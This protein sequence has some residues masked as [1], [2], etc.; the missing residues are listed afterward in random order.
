[1]ARSSRPPLTELERRA[2][3]R[4]A[5]LLAQAGDQPARRAGYEELGDEPR[6]ARR[7]GRDGRSR[8]HGGGAGARGAAAGRAP[9]RRRRYPPV[10][11]AA[12]G[13]RAPR[14]RRGRRP[15]RRRRA[16]KKPPRRRLRV[17][18]IDGRLMRR[19]GAISLRVAGGPW[20]PRR[21]ASRLPRPRSHV[22]VPLRDPAVSRRHAA[23]PARAATASRSRTPARAVASRVGGAR[24]DAPLPLRGAAS[25][26]LGAAR[27]CASPP[28]TGRSRSRGRGGLDRRPARARG[29][30]SGVPRAAVSRDRR[31]ALAL[32]PAARAWSGDPTSPCASTATSSGPAA[33][34]STATSSRSRARTAHSAGD[35]LTAPRPPKADR[36]LDEAERAE[37]AGDLAAAAVALRGH[38]DAAPRRRRA[39]CASLRVLTALGER[40]RRARALL[41]PLEAA[42]DR[43]PVRRA[44][45]SAASPSWTRRTAPSWRPRAL[46]ADPGR[47]HR[48]PAGAR[49]PGAAARRDPGRGAVDDR[50]RRRR[51]SSPAGVE[52][53]ALPPAARARA[54]R[55]RDR[56]PGARRGLDLE[57]AL[58]VLHPQ[59]AGAGRRRRAPPV[60]RRGARS[61]PACATRAS[62]PSTT[63]TRPPALAGDGV[64]R[65]AARCAT[66][67]RAQPG[68]PAA[69]TSCSATA[70][71]PARRAG[72][73]PRRAASS[74]AISS[75]R[76]C[77]C[78][79]P[80]RSC[81]PTS[82]SAE[83]AGDA[84]RR[85][86][87][88]PGHAALPRPRAVRGRARLA[89]HRSLRRGRDP[90]GSDVR[91]PAAQ[92]RRPDA[93]RAAAPSPRSPPTSAAAHR[94]PRSG[95][96]A[97]SFGVLVLRSLGT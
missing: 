65:R 82:A 5:A 96:A 44:R 40:A 39:G 73:R 1:M 28:V 57:V 76:T 97:P 74:T 20:V 66:R 92:P 71:E 41:A 36:L 54:R 4:A 46:G 62:S 68:G 88:P 7:L 87:V 22:E 86:R 89:R 90:L 70:R 9:R 94:R 79:R 93:R 21:A 33:I 16:W 77:S 27:P 67:L 23:A 35:R 78:A 32:T 95:A 31:P 51:W 24:V 8:S 19:R 83:L 12:G 14:R 42:G 11:V 59:L 64:R 17:A 10:R 84:A 25:S 34:C 81:W 13:R 18:R 61:P 75:R 52:T 2:L 85:Q 91:P 6:A 69:P 56:L 37:Q 55:D 26:A 38:L 53:L 63:S 48:R 29:R 30:R 45:R 47:R 15:R 80:A 50:S 43:R 49:P 58:K 72:L 60:L 3:N